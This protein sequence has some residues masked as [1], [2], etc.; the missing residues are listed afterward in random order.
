MDRKAPR[1]Q[2]CLPHVHESRHGGHVRAELIH[3][4]L[5]YGAIET[6]KELTELRSMTLAVARREHQRPWLQDGRAA[7]PVRIDSASRT[8]T[9]MLASGNVV[10]FAAVSRIATTSE[11]ASCSRSSGSSTSKSR[12]S[13][14]R[15]RSCFRRR[16]QSPSVARGGA[17]RAARHVPGRRSPKLSASGAGKMAQGVRAARDARA[18][19]AGDLSLL[20]R[21]R[22]AVE[23]LGPSAREAS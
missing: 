9:A 20:S 16:S 4:L 22:R 2:P 7:G 15:W 18:A 8:S 6:R 3:S 5:S 10:S 13:C 12:S 14:A 17:W 11:N 21:G 23:A 19:R 1:P